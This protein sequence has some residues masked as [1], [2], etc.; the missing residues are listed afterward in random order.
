MKKETYE[1]IEALTGK[2]TEAHEY[3][4]QTKVIGEDEA[5][6]LI[7]ICKAFTADKYT[8]KKRLNFIN[9]NWEVTV[10]KVKDPIV[11][12]ILKILKYPL[13]EM[14]KYLNLDAIKNL[15][16]KDLV[17]RIYLQQEEL[18][19]TKSN[20]FVLSQNYKKLKEAAE[21]LVDIESLEKN[22]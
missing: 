6:E 5:L 13:V 20:F 14:L 17:E 4:D 16:E 21:G 1:Q 11:F 19:K 8:L 15:K 10:K 2:T 22:N 18:E 9:E 7:K 3:G 12:K